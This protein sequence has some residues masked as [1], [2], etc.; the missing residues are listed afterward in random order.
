MIESVVKI[1]ESTGDLDFLAFSFRGKHSFSD[2][3]IYRISEGSSY[4]ESL[5]P[6]LEEKTVQIPNSDG[7]YYFGSNYKSK[8]F[9]VSFAF[10]SLTEDRY[11]MM[12]QWL[13][14]K[15]VG[16]LWFEEEPYKIY[17]AKPT[18]NLQISYNVFSEGG[19]RVYKGTGQVQFVAF[20][21]Y[22]HT[23]DYVENSVIQLEKNQSTL[24]AK[25][26]IGQYFNII[27]L[28]T[29]GQYLK[30]LCDNEW[31]APDNYYDSFVSFH[32]EKSITG[33]QSMVNAKIRI[34]KNTEENIDA[35][36]QLV[37]CSSYGLDLDSYLCF[38]NYMEWFASSGLVS[39]S[40]EWQNGNNICNFGTFPSQFKVIYD[41]TTYHDVSTHF[42]IANNQITL[43][44]GAYGVVWD[45]YTGLVTGLT[46]MGDESTRRPIKYVGNAYGKIPVGETPASEIELPL[47]AKI[48]YHYWYY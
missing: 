29:A 20:Y 46:L 12:K 13:N 23:P 7:Q 19:V 37:F 22:A 48:K 41:N 34:Y 3:G 31:I 42:K 17:V 9:N 1:P 16:D 6:S 10:D 2:F 15:E 8:N 14:G 45:S 44:E 30:F 28:A 11:Q 40:S 39:G 47:G 36:R 21:P 35:N 26:I 24:F 32:T 43:Q 25:P 18:G 38:N 5:I 4:S 33:I 27:G